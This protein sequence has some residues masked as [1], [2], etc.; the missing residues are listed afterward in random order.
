MPSKKKCSCY[1]QRQNRW[2]EPSVLLLLLEAP[3][4]GYEIIARLPEL[5]FSQSPTDPGAVYRTLRHMEENDFVESV[6]DVSGSGPAKRRYTITAAGC[7]HLALWADMLAQRR[8]AIDAFLLRLNKSLKNSV[9]EQ[10][11]I[12]AK[13]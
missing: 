9:Q 7:E 12:E 3:C 1:S 4:H 6:W 8:E 11:G 10:S 2:L 13:A 5:G